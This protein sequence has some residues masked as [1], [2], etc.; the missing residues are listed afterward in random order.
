MARRMRACLLQPF[1]APAC[2]TDILAHGC[3]SRITSTSG[4]RGRSLGIVA[5]YC[6]SKPQI[7]ME[8]WKYH[9]AMSA[10]V[11][12]SETILS[13]VIAFRVDLLLGDTA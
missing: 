13:I 4:L 2:Q 10:E 11:D 3:W 8:I 9:L 1:P 12:H 5:A 6:A 7:F